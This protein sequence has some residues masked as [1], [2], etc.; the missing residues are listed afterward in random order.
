MTQESFTRTNAGIVAWLFG[1]LVF[2]VGIFLDLLLIDVGISRTQTLLLTNA[3]TGMVAGVAGA[4][5][6]HT[7]LKR[8][9]EETHRLQVMDE[10]NHHIRNALQVVLFQCYSMEGDSANNMRRAVERIQWSLTE[11]LPQI[12]FTRS[13]FK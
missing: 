4:S 5:F 9:A 2:S 1:L 8:R 12:N 6:L 10:M 7:Q 3:I 13:N 11:V